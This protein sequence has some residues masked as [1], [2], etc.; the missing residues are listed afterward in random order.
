MESDDT[1]RSAGKELERYVTLGRISGVFG[2]QGWVKVF[3]HTRPIENILGYSPWY[4]RRGEAW[5]PFEV[6]DGKYHAR[7]LV[8]RLAGIDDRDLA[9]SLIGTDVAVRRSQLPPPQ[10]GEHYHFDLIGLAVVNREGVEL[11]TVEDI[12]ETGA[13]DVLV[14]RGE[15]AHLIPLVTGV[16]VRRIDE[17]RGV[18]EVDWGADF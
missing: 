15:K 18:I 8:A 2:V 5:Q 11:G 12:F 13:H 17:W 7:I 1:G 10:A 9:R 16:Y 14:V 4:L 6:L 3:S